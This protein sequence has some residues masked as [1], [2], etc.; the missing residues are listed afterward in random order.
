MPFAN[1][2]IPAGSLTAEQKKLLIDRVTDLY[3]ETFGEVARPNTMV[4]VDEVVDGG[5]GIGGHVLTLDQIHP[6]TD[7]ARNGA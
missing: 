1:L 6:K 7:T 3:A 5:W 2:K 4:L